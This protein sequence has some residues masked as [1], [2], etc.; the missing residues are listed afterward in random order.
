MGWFK[1][2]KVLT[3]IIV[4]AVLG[5]SINALSGQN[6][7]TTSND[8]ASSQRVEEEKAEVASVGQAAKDG[9]FEFI[10]NGVECG[11]PN[12]GSD[13]LTK[14]AQGQF[15]LLSVTVKNIGNE[16]QSLF[17]SNQYLLN[18]QG[19]KF[20]ADDAS[21]LY[22]APDGASWYSDINPGNSVNGVIVFDLP[23]DQ[24]PVSAQLHDSA[25]SN[26]VKVNL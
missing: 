3:I 12:V 8:T 9:K 16:A 13:F 5:I 26:G 2:H 21:T 10:V 11:R 25:F 18:E 7:D 22:A 6:N 14:A 24:T 20:S 4:L 17:S 1:K 23:K 15:C 19:Q